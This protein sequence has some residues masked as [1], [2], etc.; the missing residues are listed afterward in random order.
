MQIVYPQ[1]YSV[2]EYKLQHSHIVATTIRY[3]VYHSVCCNTAMY[4]L[5][6]MSNPL[7]S[8]F[9]RETPWIS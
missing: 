4:D 3:A 8:S 6:R 7:N 5:V 9:W 2:W 1:K